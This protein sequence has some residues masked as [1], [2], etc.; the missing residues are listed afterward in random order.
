MKVTKKAVASGALTAS[1]VLSP[2]A[3]SSASAGTGGAAPANT[4]TAGIIWPKCHPWPWP[5]WLCK[6]KWPTPIP[7]PSPM[8]K[9]KEP[10]PKW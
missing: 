2:L 6:D 4:K 5:S 1:L 9:P 10:A 3:V 8:P 7:I